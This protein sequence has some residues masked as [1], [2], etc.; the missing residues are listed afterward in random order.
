[1]NKPVRVQSRSCLGWVVTQTLAP[2]CLPCLYQSRK[3]EIYCYKLHIH[4]HFLSAAMIPTL[5][6]HPEAGLSMVKSQMNVQ[7]RSSFFYTI[8]SKYILATRSPPPLPSLYF[9]KS[10]FFCISKWEQKFMPNK[11]KIL[12]S[13]ESNFTSKKCPHSSTYPAPYS[14]FL[15]DNPKLSTILSDLSVFWQICHRHSCKFASQN[16]R[17]SIWGSKVS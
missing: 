11:L 13:K 12:N 14:R 5:E 15:L 8:S 9:V 2:K 16:A 10:I 7:S 6:F 1:M 4:T 17:N 3:R